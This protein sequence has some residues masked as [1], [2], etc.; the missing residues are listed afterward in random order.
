MWKRAPG[1][2]ARDCGRR[3]RL[4][5]AVA[6]ALL[7]AMPL[8]VAAQASALAPLPAS[9]AEEAEFLSALHFIV[10]GSAVRDSNLFKRP[11]A[12]AETYRAGYIGLRV[13]KQYS[14]QRFLLDVTKSTYNYNHYTY[15]NYKALDY[16]AA[17]QWALSS[18]R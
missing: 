12:T 3:F 18:R 6:T 10:G 5:I 11:D 7:A 4:R 13:N 15:L 16:N 14:L 17:W 2:A 1:G 9:F 8:R